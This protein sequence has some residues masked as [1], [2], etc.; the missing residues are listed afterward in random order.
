[1]GRIFPN[2]LDVCLSQNQVPGY[3]ETMPSIA[4][5]WNVSSLETKILP[6]SANEDIKYGGFSQLV[7]NFGWGSWRTMFGIKCNWFWKKGG[8]KD[9]TFHNSWVFMF[10]LGWGD[11]AFGVYVIPESEFGFEFVNGA[12]TKEKT[13]LSAYDDFKFA[14]QKKYEVLTPS[15]YTPPDASA[16]DKVT[17][18]I[19]K[20][21]GLDIFA[22]LNGRQG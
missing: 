19:K 17:A 7:F 1:M 18:F 5:P 13:L 22:K 3:R 9:A 6:H 16:G 14:N 12:T 8:A 4:F 20:M 10:E 2:G 21:L 15:G 11:V